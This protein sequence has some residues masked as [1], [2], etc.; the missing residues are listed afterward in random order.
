MFHRGCK[1]ERKSPN[2]RAL[3]RQT[4]RQTEGEDPNPCALALESVHL[5]RP[6]KGVRPLHVWE[7]VCVP[8][9]RPVPNARRPSDESGSL[10]WAI[11][12]AEDKPEQDDQSSASAGA[13]EDEL[14]L[15]G[16]EFQVSLTRVGLTSLPVAASPSPSSGTLDPTP[17]SLIVSHLLI[18]TCRPVG[19]R[20]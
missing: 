2:S 6:L 4:D 17:D 8:S 20:Q 9:G 5:R 1:S 15:E 10:L 3:D 11:T 12:C 19:T 7:R 13:D 14:E 16:L 18:V